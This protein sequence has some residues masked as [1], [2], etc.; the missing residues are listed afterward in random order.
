[1]NAIRQFGAVTA[2]GL[3]TIPTRLGASLVI[4]LGMACAVGALISIMSLSTGLMRTIEGTGRADRAIVLAQGSLYEFGSSLSRASAATIADAPG[5]R[6]D[7]NGKPVAS[8]EIL[9]YAS[10]IRK[11]NGL[12]SFVTVG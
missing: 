5:I 10:V 11:S 6:K 2:M 9:A 3:K 4:V 7:R 1:M 8:A 12:D